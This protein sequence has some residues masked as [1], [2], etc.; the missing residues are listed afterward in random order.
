MLG[1]SVREKCGTHAISDALLSEL[2]PN[3]KMT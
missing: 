3:G 2:L 1:C